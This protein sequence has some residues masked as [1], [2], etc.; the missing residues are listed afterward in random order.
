MAVLDH[1]EDSA[2]IPSNAIIES[3]SSDVGRSP[4]DDLTGNRETGYMW[5]HP[6]LRGVEL[7]RGVYKR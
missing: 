2:T 3:H 5:R 4:A 6:Q 1:L 7:F